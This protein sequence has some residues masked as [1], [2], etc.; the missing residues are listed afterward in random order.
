[1]NKSFPPNIDPQIFSIIAVV[2]GVILVD[3][4][5]AAEQNSIGNWII[6]AGQYVLTCAAQQQLIEQRIENYNININSKKH[7]RGGS[8]YTSGEK[9]NQNCRNDVEYL[10]EAVKRIEKEL[11]KLQKEVDP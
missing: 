9:S 1:M 3:D 2:A 8:H 5:T 10:L 7:K 11:E 4:F 6:L